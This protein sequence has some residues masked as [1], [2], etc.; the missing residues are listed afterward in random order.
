MLTAGRGAFQLYADGMLRLS[1]IDAA[2]RREAMAHPVMMAAGR[3]QRV[4]LLGGGDGGALRELLRYPDV[5]EVTLVEPEASLVELS[6]AQPVLVAEN[7]GALGSSRVRLHTSDP[8]GFLGADATR[9]DVIVVDLLD[10]EGPRR[11]KWFTRYFYRQLGEHLAPDGVGALVASASPL[12]QRQA[13]WS[14]VATVEAAG[15]VALPYRAAL[16]TLGPWGH[17]LFA[18]HPLAAP[19]GASLPA[20]LQHLDAVVLADMFT[21]APD[22]Q[23]VAADVNLLHRQVLPRYRQ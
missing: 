10:P 2:R 8:V 1:T 11:S 17:V 7:G 21:L 13:F 6:S 15:L 14:V 5:A 23:R 22:E 19:A 3:R 9:Y 12:A 4:L 18:H 20:G 16:P